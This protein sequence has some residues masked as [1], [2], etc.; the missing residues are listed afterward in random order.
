MT[1][2]IYDSEADFK[3]GSLMLKRNIRDHK[4]YGWKL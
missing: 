3:K 2:G 4:N 1:I